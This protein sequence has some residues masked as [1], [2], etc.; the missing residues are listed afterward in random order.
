[1]GRRPLTAEQKAEKAARRRKR[2]REQRL[3][4]RQAKQRQ[5]AETHIPSQ[6]LPEIIP[7]DP[8]V[9]SMSLHL[10]IRNDGQPSSRTDPLPIDRQSP[11]HATR[12]RRRSP[13][14]ASEPPLTIDESIILADGAF[15]RPDTTARL[16]APVR[17]I[18][19]QIPAD[20]IC[21]AT[22]YSANTGYRE[23]AET[24]EDEET[25]AAETPD[26][27]VPLQSEQI[28]AIPVSHSEVDHIVSP[29][30]QTRLRVQRC[31]DRQHAARLQQ[32]FQEATESQDLPFTHE[33]SALSLRDEAIP[34]LSLPGDIPDNEPRPSLALALESEP[35]LASETSVLPS[36]S[37]YLSNFNFLE[38]DEQENRS[39]ASM[40]EDDTLSQPM[41]PSLTSPSS[42]RHGSSSSPSQ[43]RGSPLSSR[44]NSSEWSDLSGL[45][46]DEPEDLILSDFLQAISN[47][48]T[49]G[50]PDFLRQQGDVYDR[51]LRTFFNHQCSCPS[52]DE[53][54]EPENTHTLQEHTE[55]V[56]RS[57]PPLQTI[58][59][60]RGN[61]CDPRASFPQWHSFLS[62]KPPEPLSLRKTQAS[63]PHDSV[64]VERQ[65][66]VDSIWLGAKSLSAIRAPGHFRLSFFPAYKS[67][68]STAQVIQPHGLDLAH[69][70]HTSIGT[71][72]T[73][74]VRF[75]VLLFFPNGARS[76]TKASANSLSL[77]RFRDL[78]D[79]IILPAIFETVPDYVRQEIPSSYD[80][81]YAKSRAYQEKPGAGRWS[82]E[83]ES[84]AFRLSY[85]I[86]ASN[87]AEFWAS[88]VEKANMHRVQTRRGEAVPYFENPR[89]LFQAHDLKNTFASQTI[90]GSLA[91]FRNI[92]LAGLHH[93]S[94]SRFN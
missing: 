25:S 4:A 28:A 70:R 84:R 41:T 88:V 72:I 6:S 54:A 24:D 55:Y 61:A 16:R 31:R 27:R 79:E 90:E 50:G 8:V 2:E 17:P 38:E 39:E 12:S 37:P 49:A 59:A 5:N 14:L 15:H 11:S 3:V 85:S 56:S 48:D 66:D 63:L 93:Y 64:T 91:L 22:P 30:S 13:R 40:L 42:S 47:Q 53:R 32:I 87:L 60:E 74:G 43:S 81:L 33:F 76:Y 57:L 94:S 51:V 82:A 45:P 78:Y 83:D 89:L 75:S 1:M 68:I 92:V 69:T 18:S 7:A 23:A 19:E 34:L 35:E 29:R 65:W 80:L 9:P 73:A 52:S 10:S 36:S 62:D 86:P 67:N 26:S 44:S 20:T 21:V 58:F 77:T 46:L 71:F